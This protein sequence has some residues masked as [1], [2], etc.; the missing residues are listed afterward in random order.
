MVMMPQN[1]VISTPFMFHFLTHF[2]LGRLCEDAGILQLNNRDLYPKLFP[3]PKPDEQA[4]IAA[5]LDSADVLAASV[6]NEC[7]ATRRLKTS[8]L[9]NLL[10][11]KVRV[12]MEN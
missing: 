7:R 5:L 3:V 10:T 2:K 6:E 8:L 12:K 1:E 11:G 9:Q 4:Q